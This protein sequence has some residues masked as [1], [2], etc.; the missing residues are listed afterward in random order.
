[1]QTGVPQLYSDPMAP[2]GSPESG[3][4][5][6]TTIL[7]LFWLADNNHC[8]VGSILKSLGSFPCMEK[9]ELNC[10]FPFLEIE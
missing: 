6:N 8:P 4:K 5:R 2:V 10:S 7:W 1:M 3:S 9:L